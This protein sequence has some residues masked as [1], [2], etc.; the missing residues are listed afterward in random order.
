MTTSRPHTAPAPGRHDRDAGG[1]VVG[2]SLVV[3]V[4]A[5]GWFVVG[6]T[7]GRVLF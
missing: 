3:A 5:A 6:L 1:G 2:W 7:A 4:Y